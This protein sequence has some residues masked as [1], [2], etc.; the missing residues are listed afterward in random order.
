MESRY[1]KADSIWV[2]DRGMVSEENIELLKEGKRRYI[3]GTP[4][5]MLRKFE[6]ELLSEDWDTVHEG[7]EV[8]LCPSPDGEETF[9]L[10][11][12]DDRRQEEKAM[13][14]SPSRRQ[15]SKA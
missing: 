1:G 12:S 15:A 5:G 11:R 2:M 6:K 14:P 7:L 13:H 4:K 8:K 9:I 3:L 10:C